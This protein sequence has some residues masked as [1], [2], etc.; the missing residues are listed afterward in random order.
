LE[1][2]PK[3]GVFA[4]AYWSSFLRS[5]SQKNEVKKNYIE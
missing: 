1:V 2:L 3:G 4:S 5:N